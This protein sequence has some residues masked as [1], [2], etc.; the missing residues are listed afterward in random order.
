[1]KILRKYNNQEEQSS[2]WTK[3]SRDEQ[4]NNAKQTSVMNA[5]TNP[6]KKNCNGV[7]VL[8]WSVENITG[9]LTL[10]VPNFRHLSSASFIL[11][12]FSLQM[13]FICKVETECQT[14]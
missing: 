6:K 1:M 7:T 10:S 4:K 2:R 14:A 11:T 9:G 12:E 3:R 13:T 5:P 8:D